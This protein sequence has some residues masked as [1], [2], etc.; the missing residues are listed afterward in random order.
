MRKMERKVNE[1][2]KNEDIIDLT[3]NFAIVLVHFK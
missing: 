1:L 3:P 2:L